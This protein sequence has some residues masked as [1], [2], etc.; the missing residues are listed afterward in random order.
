MSAQPLYAPPAPDV[1]ERFAYTVCQE[2]GSEFA[3]SEVIRGFSQFVNTVARV[4][5]NNLNRKPGSE[6]DQVLQ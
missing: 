3:D 5:A 1:V 4:H 2:L 6:G